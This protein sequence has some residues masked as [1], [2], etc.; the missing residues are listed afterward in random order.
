MVDGKEDGVGET[1][2]ELVD[3]DHLDNED[4]GPGS[5]F[6][7]IDEEKEKGEEEDMEEEVE[8]ELFADQHEDAPR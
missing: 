2:D 5:G 7:G 6:E 1:H 4:S 8:L 3:K